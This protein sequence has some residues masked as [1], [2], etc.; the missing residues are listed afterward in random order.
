MDDTTLRRCGDE[1]YQA[2]VR[3]SPIRP[4]TERHPEVTIE[5]AYHIAQRMVQRRLEQGETVIGKKIGVTSAPVQ[6]MLGVHQPD[7]G[8]L[9]S[10]MLYND[11]DLILS[12]LM[13]QPRAEAELAFVLGA[14]LKGPGVTVEQVLEATEAVTPCF[15]IV[16]SRIQDWAIQI[17]DTVADNASSGVFVLGRQR[18]DPRSL[19]LARCTIVVHKNGREISRGTGEEALTGQPKLGS[20]VACVA[21]LANTLAPFGIGLEA[22]EII[23]S[24]SLVPLEPVARGDVMRLEAEGLGSV[25]AKFM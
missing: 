15:E 19:D 7:F 6:N 20:P 16:D 23:L 2:F 24:G 3:R 25:T 1:L 8:W 22:G 4:L 21:W 13:I 14:P 10:S 11:G 18:R 9:T 5:E 12:D 17:Q